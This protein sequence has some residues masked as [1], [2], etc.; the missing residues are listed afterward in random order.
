MI[1]VSFDSTQD[2][3]SFA[4]TEG[5]PF[6]LVSDLDRATA[7][8]YGTRRPPEDPLADYASRRVTFLID[9]GGIVRKVWHRTRSRCSPIWRPSARSGVR[10]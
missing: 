6:L 10:R 7:E 4:E 5:F 1:G 2:N 3:K 8:L 9:P